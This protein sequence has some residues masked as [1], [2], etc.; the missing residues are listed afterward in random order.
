MEKYLSIRIRRNDFTMKKV[1]NKVYKSYSQQLEHDNR[2]E[3]I[4]SGYLQNKDKQHLNKFTNFIEDLS[5][6]NI[7]EKW[8]AAAEEYENYFHRKM[9]KTSKP[10]ITGV[11]T[12]SSSMIEDYKK[13]PNL[14]DKINDFLLQEFGQ[15]NLYNVIHF[16]E[17][18]P[19]LHFTLL[20]FDY[21]TKKTISNNINTS[22]LQDKLYNFLAEHFENFEYKRG[23]KKAETKAEHLEVRE[24]QALEIKNSHTE[25]KNLKEQVNTLIEDKNALQSKYDTLKAE[26]TQDIKETKTELINVHTELETVLQDME[27]FL[28]TE[29]DKDKWQ[30]MKE[31][32]TKY[33]EKE[34][35]KRLI[36]TLNKAKRTNKA[37][38]KKYNKMGN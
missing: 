19:H 34:N 26:L 4:E 12:F 2:T 25:I 3:K 10:I 31:L 37:I 18:T 27:Q 11:I 36:E 21:Q 13:Y 17:K 38:K 6:E 14:N 15:S 9:P 22:K 32:T 33:T 5:E 7:K 30:K 1:N 16:D 23:R 35:V 28:L 8:N 20:N 24:A 29:S